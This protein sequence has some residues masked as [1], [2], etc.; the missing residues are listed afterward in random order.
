MDVQQDVSALLEG[1]SRA[2]AQLL[3]ASRLFLESIQASPQN[4]SALVMNFETKRNI[5]FCAVELIDRKI[6]TFS[7]HLSNSPEWKASA[8]RTILE[9]Q[10]LVREILKVDADI[11]NVI[12]HHRQNLLRE[13]TD[14][15]RLKDRLSK[16][17]SQQVHGQ[18]EGL[19]QQL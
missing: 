9:H 15:G 5:T 2:L 11:I 1:K 8:R 17:K 14:Q 7:P 16:F 4:L 6:S 10:E 12:E 19:D 18:G 13:A 3:E